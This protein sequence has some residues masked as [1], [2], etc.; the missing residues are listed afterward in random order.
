MWFMKDRTF[1]P[2]ADSCAPTDPCSPTNPCSPENAVPE[3][4]GWPPPDDAM[5]SPL[6]PSADSD[7]TADLPLG[8]A[9]AARRDGWRPE[10]R[11]TF[12]E[13]VAE[14][15]RITL[16][17]QC[18]RMS[19]QSAYALRARDPVFAASWDAACELAR[20][21]LAD[22]LYERA[23]CGV[24][25]TISRDGKVIAE[26]HRHDNRL[27][28]AV[29]QRLDRRCE[30]SWQCGARHMPLLANW[31][32]WLE[33]VGEGEDV[34]ANDALRLRGPH[35]QLHQLP[36]GENPTRRRRRSGAKRALHE[37]DC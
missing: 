33:R 9:A 12:L 34:G 29:L 20:Q 3:P 37:G 21:P 13:V 24:T 28:M 27:S 25:E 14:T 32:E 23:L 31:E 17:C 7:P 15:G 35:R 19:P 6:A 4:T 8:T 22:A 26:R 16:A 2:L 10:A 5:A 11:R 30:R 18:C 36:L 1:E